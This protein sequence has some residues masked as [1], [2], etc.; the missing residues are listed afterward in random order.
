MVE[1]LEFEELIVDKR[2][3]DFPD[4]ML[5]K[6]LMPLSYIKDAKAMRELLKPYKDSIRKK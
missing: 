1:E 3:M 6:G 2:H 4:Q 5:D